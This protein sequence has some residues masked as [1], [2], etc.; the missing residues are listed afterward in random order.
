MAHTTRCI[1]QG[2]TLALTM[3]TVRRILT[4]QMVDGSPSFLF[5]VFKPP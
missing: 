3:P 5:L 4:P 1:G 2:G